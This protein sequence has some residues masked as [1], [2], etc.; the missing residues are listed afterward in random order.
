M[1]RT[2]HPPAA[3]G[4]PMPAAAR[5]SVTAAPRA[6]PAQLKDSPGQEE[7]RF[8]LTGELA[9]SKGAPSQRK[10]AIGSAETRRASRQQRRV[11]R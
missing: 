1:G 10:R 6:A 4:Q 7:A 11:D 3:V 5:C 8:G 2:R 9:P